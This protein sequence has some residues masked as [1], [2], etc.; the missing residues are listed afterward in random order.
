MPIVNVAETLRKVADLV[1]STAEVYNRPNTKQNFGGYYSNKDEKGQ[2]ADCFCILAA[3]HIQQNSLT[4]EQAI[5]LFRIPESADEEWYV[6]APSPEEILSQ[7]DIQGHMW[8]DKNVTP[9]IETIYTSS[10][11]RLVGEIL[12]DKYKLTP[13]EISAKLR[14]F[15]DNT[16][17]DKTTYVDRFDDEH[18][19]D[20]DEW[21][22]LTQ[23][24]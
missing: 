8:L 12:N 14:S 2:P 11:S 6:E 1:D 5:E 9:A 21:T 10:L 22:Q 20:Y 18:D 13:A 24:A 7:A 16:P 3:I 4:T 15:A 23:L 19:P 17:A